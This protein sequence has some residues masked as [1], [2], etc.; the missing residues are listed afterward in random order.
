MTVPENLD[1]N[2]TDKA[3]TNDDG[4]TEFKEHVD[5]LEESTCLLEVKHVPPELE[6]IYCNTCKL[7]CDKMYA[8]E[9]K[10]SRPDE[11]VAADEDSCN[12]IEL[13]SS[14][15]VI[16]EVVENDSQVQ[17]Q[18]IKPNEVNVATLCVLPCNGYL[19]RELCSSPAPTRSPTCSIL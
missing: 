4:C 12:K 18:C 16:S 19:Y 17:N 7:F 10:P 1:S 6:H 14:M 15:E 2:Q 13:L 8:L 9:D 5:K 11:D 3:N